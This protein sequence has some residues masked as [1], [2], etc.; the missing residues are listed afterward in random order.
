MIAETEK[1]KILRGE[2]VAAYYT[3]EIQQKQMNKQHMKCGM[4]R[5]PT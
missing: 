1:N 3:I 4:A 2:A 5:N